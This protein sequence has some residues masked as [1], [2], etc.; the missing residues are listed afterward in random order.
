M[1]TTQK[2]SLGWINGWFDVMDSSIRKQFAHSRK[3][4]QLNWIRHLVQSKGLRGVWVIVRLSQVYLGETTVQCWYNAITT[5]I[6]CPIE[7]GTIPSSRGVHASQDREKH[8]RYSFLFELNTKS[9]ASVYN[10]R[11]DAMSFA[12]GDTPAGTLPAMIVQKCHNVS[13]EVGMCA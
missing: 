13:K 2:R 8:F 5:M 3:T 10:C 4:L 12:K 9:G 7:Q 6:L 1:H 11:T